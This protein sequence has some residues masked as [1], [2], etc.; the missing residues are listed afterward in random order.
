MTGKPQVIL[1]DHGNPAFAV[2]PWKDYE[3]LAPDDAGAAL[4]DE[5]LYDRAKAE[6][7]EEFPIDVA[8]RILAGENPVQVFRNHRKMTQRELAAAAGITPLY[9]SQIETGKR[10][11]STKVL[12]AIAKALSVGLD[13]LV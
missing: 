10:G 8:D 2:I 1:D 6:D 7:G 12:S 13:D 9:L 11:G 4:S 5:E 3:R